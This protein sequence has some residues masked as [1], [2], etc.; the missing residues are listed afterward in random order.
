MK[1]YNLDNFSV[2]RY[3]I[4][5]Y[6]EDMDDLLSSNINV[7]FCAIYTH[8]CRFCG[9]RVNKCKFNKRGKKNFKNLRRYNE[10]S[11]Y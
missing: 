6:L 2:N 10:N 4:K 1:I 5:E 9:Q 8:R 3:N 11:Q 7:I